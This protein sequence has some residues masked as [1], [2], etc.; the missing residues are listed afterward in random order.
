MGGLLTIGQLL[1]VFSIFAFSLGVWLGPKLKD[2]V[3]RTPAPLRNEMAALEASL[4]THMEAELRAALTKIRVSA[5]LAPTTAPVPPSPVVLPPD[6][7]AGTLAGITGP[8]GPP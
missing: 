1:A 8:I 3:L 2:L 7:P 4:K 5:G 6:P